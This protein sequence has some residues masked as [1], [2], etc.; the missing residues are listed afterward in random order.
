LLHKRTK[1]IEALQKSSA[2][3]PNHSLQ[4]RQDLRAIHT[5]VLSPQ[6][7]GTKTHVDSSYG[8]VLQNQTQ[9]GPSAPWLAAS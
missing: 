9:F 7:V 6:N 4:I 1:Q 3:S 2:F 5:S 8:E